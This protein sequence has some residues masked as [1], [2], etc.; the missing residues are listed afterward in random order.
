[1][2]RGGVLM[3]PD[4]RCKN[5]AIAYAQ[6]EGTVPRPV[7]ILEYPPPDRPWDVVSI[8]LLQLPASHQ[9]F[10]YLLVCVDYLSRYIILAPVLIAHGLMTQL[11]CTYSTPRV[12]LSDKWAEFCNQL[13]E[14]IMQST[15]HKAQT[16]SQSSQQRPC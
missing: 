7:P 4:A 14:E 8:D 16:Y 12:L 11:F 5:C 9:G 2:G 3:Q 10:K 15:W 6:H 1:M 13:F